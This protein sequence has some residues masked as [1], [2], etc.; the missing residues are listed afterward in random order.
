MTI[1]VEPEFIRTPLSLLQPIEPSILNP[2]PVPAVEPILVA[3]DMLSENI[4]PNELQAVQLTSSKV[5]S[6]RIA[7]MFHYGG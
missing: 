3:N 5:P 4:T 1:K 2:D 6:S 7:R